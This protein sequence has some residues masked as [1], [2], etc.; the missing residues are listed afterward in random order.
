VSNAVAGA[1]PSRGRPRSEASRGNHD[2][3]TRSNRTAEPREAGKRV[4]RVRTRRPGR[5]RGS[6]SY[7]ALNATTGGDDG[8]RRLSAVIKRL[9]AALP[10]SD[11]QQFRALRE[12]AGRRRGGPGSKR[13]AW[14]GTVT[15]L[16]LPG[17][18]YTWTRFERGVVIDYLGRPT[19]PA[20]PRVA[21]RDSGARARHGRPTRPPNDRRAPSPA[22]TVR[23]FTCMCGRIGWAGKLE[24]PASCRS[25]GNTGWVE[26]FSQVPNPVYAI[27]KMIAMLRRRNRARGC[28]ACWPMLGASA[29]AVAQPK[30][31]LKIGRQRCIRNYS[32]T[33]KRRR[34]TCP[35][36]EGAVDPA[37]GD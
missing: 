8:D 32:W 22:L 36:Y 6:R 20:K 19:V 2:D 27:R 13:R 34:W 4:W 17:S 24:I 18:D 14:A 30:P 28:W 29:T 11:Q 7:L 1:A 31:P 21:A 35:G 5:H 3:P 37:G 23:R 25:H 26:V 16:A 9:A 15:T 33:R 12:K 10:E